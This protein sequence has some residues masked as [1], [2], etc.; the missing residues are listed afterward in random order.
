MDQKTN[1][2]QDMNVLFDKLEQFT[3]TES[4]MGKPVAFGDKTLIPIVSVTMGYGSGPNPMSSLNPAKNQQSG[5]GTAG[6]GVGARIA[7]NAVV[8]IENNSV[9]MLPVHEKN[10]LGQMID[11]LP[12][13]VSN[14]MPGGQQQAQQN[15]QNQQA[16]QQNQPQQ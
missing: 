1:F 10:N 11:K 7:T 5:N 16:Q 2:A 14:L 15:Q 12:Q 3:K 4:V 13:M 6:L 9:S 8:V